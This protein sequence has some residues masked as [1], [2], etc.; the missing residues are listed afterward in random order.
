MDKDEANQKKV[1]TAVQCSPQ[2]ARIVE[3]SQ[4]TSFRILQ[5]A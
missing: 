3:G 2:T 1:P 5:I 4:I